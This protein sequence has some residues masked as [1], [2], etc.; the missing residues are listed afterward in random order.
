[1]ATKQPRFDEAQLKHYR[2][3]F[4]SFDRDSSGAIDA[5]ELAAMCE[6]SLGIPPPLPH[7]LTSSSSPPHVLLIYIII[8]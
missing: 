6:R 2:D 5:H 8:V 1:M 3:L 7:L 4:D